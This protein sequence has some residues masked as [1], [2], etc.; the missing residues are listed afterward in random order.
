MIN[1]S[2]ILFTGG[3]GLLGT[4]IKSLLPECDYPTSSEFNVTD[5]YKM[6]KY[7]KLKKYTLII[8]AAA[9]TSPPLI[10]KDPMKALEVNILGTA[11]IVKLCMKSNIKLF[12]ISTDYV[13]KGDT[14]N[15]KEDDPVNPVNKY[16]WSK[17]GG[18]C[19]VRLYDNSLIIRTS[20]S[21]DVFPY[22]KA[23]EDQ[24]TS[25]ECVSVI[26]KKIYNLINKNIT[27][28]IHIGGKRKTVLDYARQLNKNMHIEKLSRDDVNFTVPVDTSLNCEKYKT[29][30][31]IRS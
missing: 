17:L 7:L 8:H 12:Y 3:S 22:D 31:N 9:F 1:Q 18:E 6:D 13:F 23:F 14:G 16:A 2:D 28:I 24:W 30:F 19:A 25:R 29:F 20:F 26:A 27:G 21:P 11:N 10:N 15:Y 5:F 4:T